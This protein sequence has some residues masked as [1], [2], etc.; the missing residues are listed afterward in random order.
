MT[1]Q[2]PNPGDAASPTAEGGAALGPLSRPVLVADANPGEALPVRARLALRIPSLD[3]FRAVSIL[4]VFLSHAGLRNVIPG[5][6]GV[7]V[8]FFLSG[9]LITTLLRQEWQTTGSISLRNFYLRRVFRIFPPLYLT[10]IFATLVTLVGLL[11]AKLTSSAFAAQCFFLAN[12][13]KI[14]RFGVGMPPGML[15][16]WSLAV[17][18]HFYF[19]FPFV[20]VAMQK[21]KVR[22]GAQAAILFGLCAVVL[23]WRFALIHALGVDVRAL[24]AASGGWD[25]GWHR[26]AE[27]TDTR[28]DSIL[29]GCIL[30]VW[31]NPVLDATSLSPR[32]WKWVLFPLGVAMLLFSFVYRSDEF[33]ETTRYTLQGVAL[34][35]IFVAAI[36]YPEWIVFRPLQSRWMGRLGL[37]SYTFYL[38]HDT[39]IETAAHLQGRVT[40]VGAVASFALTIAFC[41]LSYRF[42]E[43][44]FAIL[45]KR[46]A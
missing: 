41:E 31:G 15:V 42:V 24:N 32:L 11:P 30:A 29:F 7:T 12:Y 14:Y 8:F 4:I 44:P 21:R 43:T 28:L 6:F 17:E 35:P 36:R 33:R 34:M 39:F 46:L 37:L 22:A 18:E 23:A 10:L 13:F 1:L 25:A 20:F 9:Y 38:V 3:G 26:L 27:A 5:T 40:V 19:V 45:R 16:L 2:S